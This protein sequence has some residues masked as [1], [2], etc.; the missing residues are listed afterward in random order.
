MNKRRVHRE[1]LVMFNLDGIRLVGS[2]T[3]LM[4]TIKLNVS[5]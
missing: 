4:V 3:H 1:M 5:R 2:C